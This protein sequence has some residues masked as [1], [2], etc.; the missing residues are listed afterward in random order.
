MTVP[1][2]TVISAPRKVLLD[3]AFS[4]TLCYCLRGLADADASD[5]SQT[6][7]L[8]GVLIAL[9][10]RG[11]QFTRSTA[12]SI[13]D[14]LRDILKSNP[15]HPWT[16]PEASR[17][18]A[19]SEAT[20]RRRLAKERSRFEGLLVE[21]R[22]HHAMTLLQTTTWSVPQVARACGYSSRTRF[23]ERFREQFGCLPSRAR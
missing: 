6:H 7:R 5:Q 1:D 23:T 19:M 17:A 10:D 22:M 9:A 16:A 14:R 18:L 20:L 4:D 11:C 15:S 21:V 8:I 3:S 2:E 13:A 12:P